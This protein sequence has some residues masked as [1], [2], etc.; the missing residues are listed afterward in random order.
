MD[1]MGNCGYTCETAI[2]AIESGAADLIAIGR[3]LMSTPDLVER[4][5][6]GLPL[7]PDI[8]MAH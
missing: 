4:Y 6:E 8:D 2:E 5:R 3:P 7:N 1:D